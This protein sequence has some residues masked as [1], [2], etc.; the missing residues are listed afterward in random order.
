MRTGQHTQTRG[1]LSRPLFDFEN[2]IQVLRR[3]SQC[4]LDAS[5][6]KPS[7]EETGEACSRF[8]FDDEP[9]S[10]TVALGFEVAFMANIR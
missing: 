7:I 9:V 8:V 1:S 6:E 4:L 3:L 10:A 2:P 5:S